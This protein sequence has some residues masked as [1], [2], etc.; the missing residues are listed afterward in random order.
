MNPYIILTDSSCDLP[1]WKLEELGVHIAC[2]TTN[3]EGKTYINDAEW[4]EISPS[5]FY[6][7]LRAGKDAKT[8][9]ANVDDFKALMTPV[10]EEGKDILY[11]GFSSGLSGTYNAGRLAAEELAAR[12]PDRKIRTVDSLSASLGQGL[13]VALTCEK[14]DAGAT[15]DEAADYCEEIKLKICHWFTVDDLHF[16]HRGGRVSKSVA[17]IGS[18]LGIK[19]VMYMDNEGHLTKRKCA[20]AE[21]PPFAGW[22]NGWRT[23]PFPGTWP[24][25]AT[26]TAPTRLRRWPRC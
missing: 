16:L 26:A 9:A 14:R 6:N 20:G 19:P 17:V 24:T 2:L 13:L 22:R 21:R 7:A 23:P 12:Y 18:A 5:D 25:S 10:L 15:L 11:I 3:M 8:S 1:Q 4:R